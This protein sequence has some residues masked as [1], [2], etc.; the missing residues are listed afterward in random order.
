MEAASEDKGN[1]VE[2]N[3]IKSN[4]VE[5]EGGIKRFKVVTV[6]IVLFII[7]KGDCNIYK[8]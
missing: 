1:E 7:L 5:I 3:E 4:D 2:G 8:P 6:I